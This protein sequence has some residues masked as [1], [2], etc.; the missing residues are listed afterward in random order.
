MKKNIKSKKIEKIGLVHGVFDAIHIGHLW[1][2]KNAKKLVDKLIVSVTSDKYVN[3]GPGKPIFDINKRVELLESINIIDEVI[4]SHNKT[5][6][7]IIKKIKPDF[8]IKGGDYRD[9]KSDPTDQIKVEK[10]VV[11]SVG[12]KLVFTNSPLF[13]GKSRCIISSEFS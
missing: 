1:Y 3:K 10:K 11:E 4:I 13:S 8:Y 5:A 7:E 2:F 9:L 6:V 12:G